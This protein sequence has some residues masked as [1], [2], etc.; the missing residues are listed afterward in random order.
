MAREGAG[1]GERVEWGREKVRLVEVRAKGSGVSVRGAT[2]R[3]QDRDNDMHMRVQA[4]MRANKQDGIG[5]LFVK[6]GEK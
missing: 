4:S 5:F 1:G 6:I 2:R 3:L